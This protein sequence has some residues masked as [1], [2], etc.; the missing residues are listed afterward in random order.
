MLLSAVVSI[1]VTDY[2]TVTIEPCSVIGRGS[3]HVM[4]GYRACNIHKDGFLTQL[5]QIRCGDIVPVIVLH[6]H[7][8]LFVL[9]VE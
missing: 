6:S 8:H 2:I 7:E 3:R 5:A 9:M 4:R 1:D